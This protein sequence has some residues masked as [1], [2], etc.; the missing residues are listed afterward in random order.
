MTDDDR[1]Q[2]LD[3]EIAAALDVAPSPDL[4]A[5]IR[6]RLATEDAA[7]RIGLRVVAA[8]ACAVL[9]IAAA[10]AFYRPAEETVPVGR[11]IALVNGGSE[12]QDP[13][14]VQNAPNVRS[15]GLVRQNRRPTAPPVAVVG[16][17]H[18][19]PE[20]ETALRPSSDM[21]AIEEFM[22]VAMLEEP[23]IAGTL[24]AATSIN[25]QVAE[26]SIVPLEVT[27]LTPNE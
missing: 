19:S 9:A 12:E 23:V 10:L 27:P 2:Q 6:Q 14:Y 24:D 25:I 1:L 13:P 21:A 26:L 18:A 8:F 20:R 5:R 17:T 3:R 22:E 16:A 15:P 11:D 4:V 7:P